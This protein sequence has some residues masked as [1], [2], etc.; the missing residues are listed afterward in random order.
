M[1]KGCAMNR[2][3][4]MDRRGFLGGLGAAGVALGMAGPAAA[5]TV[6]RSFDILRGTSRI[7][8]QS[9][10]VT[11]SGG[12]VSV[13]IDI[14]IAVRIL[15]LPAYRYTLASRERWQNG[16]LER[17]SAK[18][19][20]NGTRQ[21]VEAERQSGGLSVEGSAHRG[22]VSGNPAT[23]TYWAVGMLNRPVWIN[24]QN[25]APM[26]I[27]A[28]SAGQVP[29]TLGDGAT[30]TARKWRCTG[31]IGQLDLFYDG[32]DEWIGNAFQARGQDIRM[33]VTQRGGNMA[34][35]WAEA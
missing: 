2:L 34:Q 30:V 13:A 6:T 19:N 18:G 26:N 31:D 20:D 24:T 14:D 4:D 8:S 11:R 32:R 7:G 35:L 16:V 25:G 33:V 12:T 27:R 23:T 29:F 21:F 22:T 10:Q 1:G 15:G 28:R 17:L 3:G 5:R 9:L